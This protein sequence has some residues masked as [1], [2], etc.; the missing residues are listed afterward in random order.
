MNLLR[1]GGNAFAYAQP[2]AD[3]LTAIQVN[4]QG[5][6]VATGKFN[7]E[8]RL[9][10]VPSLT[11]FVILQSTG[12]YVTSLAWSPSGD[13]L[14]AT[15]YQGLLQV[16]N[17]P[18]NTL[19]F[20]LD[21]NGNNT[22][23]G[24]IAVAW[25]SAGDQLVTTG[26]TSGTTVFNAQTGTEI[27]QFIAGDIS[28][29]VWGYDDNTIIT[30]GNLGLR[31]WN[32]QNGQL[33]NEIRTQYPGIIGPT[34][35]SWDRTRSFLAVLIFDFSSQNTNI[36]Q[37]IDVR[38]Y[39]D[40]IIIRTIETNANT[41][42][43]REIV[44]SP[45]GQFIAGASQDGTI[46]L[47]NIATGVETVVVSDEDA[48]FT[49]DWLPSG[50]RLL[51]QTFDDVTVQSID[52]SNVIATPTPTPTPTS[53]ATDAPSPT[54]TPTDTPTATLTPSV[55]P[56]AT[57][58]ATPNAPMMNFHDF[59]VGGIVGVLPGYLKPFGQWL[60]DHA[61]AGVWNQVGNRL[62]RDWVYEAT[63]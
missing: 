2:P 45:N 17:I 47:W 7:G 12:D 32:S 5:N 50:D 49:V 35:L 1:A 14:A 6:Y 51:F 37:L 36:T 44:W 11:P 43:I 25:S 57:N 10:N 8:I 46:R 28:D 62:K 24:I 20:S 9:L 21:V 27:T 48:I 18:A 16:W 39:S 40:N 22:N 38:H 29:V 63:L 19:R 34:L 31:Y 54:P 56:T 41:D 53:T 33:I 15:S 3:F 60:A 52:V 4:P 30:A 26:Q 58:T 23:D 13:A 61:S 42:A 59:I 55:T